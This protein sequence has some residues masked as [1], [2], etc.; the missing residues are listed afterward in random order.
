MIEAAAPS[1]FVFIRLMVAAPVGVKT[2][3]RF[4]KGSNQNLDDGGVVL[5][6]LSN[7]LDFSCFVG[8]QIT[9]QTDAAKNWLLTKVPAFYSDINR[10]SNELGTCASESDIAHLIA[11][12]RTLG[13]AVSALPADAGVF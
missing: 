6:D 1:R 5:F 8:D 4:R 11:C 12:I 3:G 10:E 2:P 9:D 7:P 13:T